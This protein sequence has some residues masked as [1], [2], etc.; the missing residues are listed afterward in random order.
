MMH[1]LRFRLLLTFM[2]VIAVA[3]GTLALVSSRATTARFEHYVQANV[4]RDQ[5]IYTEISTLYGRHLG[6]AEIQRA[7]EQIGKTYGERIV[8]T[9]TTGRIMADSAGELVGQVLVCSV[10]AVVSAHLLVLCRGG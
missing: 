5:R 10:P 9:D 7:V 1:S 8:L 2:I 4:E 3:L 6:A